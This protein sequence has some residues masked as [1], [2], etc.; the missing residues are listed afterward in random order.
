MTGYYGA[1]TASRLALWAQR[2]TIALPAVGLPSAL[3]AQTYSTGSG[4]YNSPY[5]QG[6]TR[7]LDGSRRSGVYAQQPSP[8]YDQPRRA[9]GRERPPEYTPP[10]IWRGV[11]AGANIGYRSN[12]NDIR[13]YNASI[14][15]SSVQL[16]GHLG[17]NMQWGQLVFGIE[18][19]IT[20]SNGAGNSA[21]NGASVMLRDSWAATLRARAG[22]AI[23][24][25]LIYGTAGVAVADQVVTFSSP[26]VSG[27]LND[28]KA[29]FVFG[30]GIDYKIAPQIS[31][32][33]EAL[34]YSYR[35][36]TLNWGP[37][38]Q[39]IRQD[40]NVL[41]AGVSVHFN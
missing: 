13:G 15:N 37:G 12:Q 24:Q 39:A 29:G 31:T 41:R 32:R 35:E 25:A 27:T 7:P 18:S 23:G 20:H 28:T 34:H 17:A 33:L 26:S 30:A 10:A 3:L 9:V 4:P 6:P 11:Y 16:G 8:R 2:L 5:T 22:Y 40:S 1:A 19:D 14:A 38:A 36:Q 21:V